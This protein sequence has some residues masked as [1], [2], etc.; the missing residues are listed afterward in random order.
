MS[1][2]TKTNRKGSKPKS[3]FLHS[4]SFKLTEDQY[5]TICKEFLGCQLG[6]AAMIAQP[7][8]W[9]GGMSHMRLHPP[10]MKVTVIAPELY[11]KLQA[12]LPKRVKQMS[13]QKQHDY[14]YQEHDLDGIIRYF[15]NGFDG[16]ILRYEFWVDTHRR[17]V[18][19]KLLVEK[20]VKCAKPR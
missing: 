7:H 16:K 18:V 13:N 10:T 1:I 6:R 14:R 19:F 12:V 5:Q 9:F 20:D 4:F 8:I 17:S 3:P 15:A 2:K 11:E